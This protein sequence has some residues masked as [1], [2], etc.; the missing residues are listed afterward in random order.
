MAG[1]D[2]PSHVIHLVSQ[3]SEFCYSIAIAFLS[4]FGLF[5]FASIRLQ[6]ANSEDITVL[7]YRTME[8][9]HEVQRT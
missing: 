7:L 2:V 1:W 8:W 4:A 5:A 3:T 6:D 9:V